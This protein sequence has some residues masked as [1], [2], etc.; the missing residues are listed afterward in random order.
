MAPNLKPNVKLGEIADKIVYYGGFN[1]GLEF[2]SGYLHSRYSSTLIIRGNV[3]MGKKTLVKVA[4]KLYDDLHKHEKRN[5]PRDEQVSVELKMIDV[6]PYHYSDDYS[7]IR[8]IAKQLG[9]KLK[10]SLQELLDDIEKLSSKGEQ[11]I[12][13]VLHDFEEF[14][15]QRQSLLYGLTQLTQAGTY[16][17]LIGLT[18]ALDCTE[19]LEK[20]VRSR[21]NAK[22]FEL[23]PYRRREEFVQFA[24]ELLNGHPIEGN[25]KMQLEF[26]HDVGCYSIR[27]L[28]RYLISLCSWDEKGKFSL[29][30]PENPREHPQYNLKRFAERLKWLTRDQ[31]ELLKMAVCYCHSNETL[32]FCLQALAEFS[33]LRGHHKFDTT[34]SLAFKNISTLGKMCLI[35]SKKPDEAPSALSQFV[36]CVTPFELKQ[37]LVEHKELQYLKTDPL[38]KKLR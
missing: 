25:L 23:W 18:L 7:A 31:L 20:R 16:V 30:Q 29:N 26:M 11:K 2:V 14:C 24:S 17:T 37:T 1:D 33:S 8:D 28:K 35:R 38:W 5:R 12:V 9:R 21:L 36:C 10:P 3:G 19:N 13:I 4:A 32:T 6:V 22:F 27:E 34:S 15:K